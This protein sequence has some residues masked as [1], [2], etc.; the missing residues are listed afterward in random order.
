MAAQ[1]GAR[2]GVNIA[3]ESL[4]IRVF[5]ELGTCGAEVCTRGK[6]PVGPCEQRAVHLHVTSGAELGALRFMQETIRA[7]VS[8][9]R[10]V[11]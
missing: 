1:T 10:V 6:L 8:V 5:T 3:G 11:Q 7:N 9:F 2:L 4:R